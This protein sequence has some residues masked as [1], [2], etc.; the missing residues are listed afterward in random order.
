MKHLKA[1][2]SSTSAMNLQEHLEIDF[3]FQINNS[4]KALASHV[5]L[6][7]YSLSLT[8]GIYYLFIQN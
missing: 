3:P 2:H 7:F 5:V 4:T 1:D 6:E 8:P